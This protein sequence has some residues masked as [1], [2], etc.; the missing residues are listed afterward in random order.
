MTTAIGWV[1]KVMYFKYHYAT[2]APIVDVPNW[3]G[4]FSVCDGF[5]LFT[6]QVLCQNIAICNLRADYLGFT[7]RWRGLL[8]DD[9]NTWFIQTRQVA[10]PI[11]Y[12][13]L[14]TCSSSWTLLRLL[15]IHLFDK[16]IHHDNPYFILN[17]LSAWGL[18]HECAL[19]ATTLGQWR[20]LWVYSPSPA[21]QTI[22]ISSLFFKY[23]W[24]C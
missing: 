12:F 2:T 9:A 17:Y 21:L 6:N 1:C 22:P 11:A 4:Q 19:F 20:W 5:S 18:V 10:A 13:L 8:L 15:H 7:Y 14:N 3:R 23:E 16:W 24:N